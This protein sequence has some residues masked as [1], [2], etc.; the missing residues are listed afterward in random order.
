MGDHHPFHLF[1]LDGDDAFDDEIDA[2]VL[3]EEVL[4]LDVDVLRRKPYGPCDLQKII[5]LS[6]PIIFRFSR[7]KSSLRLSGVEMKVIATGNWLRLFRNV[8]LFI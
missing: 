1:Q 5:L 2:D 6:K 3:Q 7:K 8:I 4:V